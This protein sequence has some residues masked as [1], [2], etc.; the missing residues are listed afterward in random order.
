MTLALYL[1]QNYLSGF[2][3]RKPAFR[4]LEPALRRAVAVDAVAVVE[5]SVHER[6]SRPRPDLGLLDLLRELS[7]GRRLPSTLDA[8]SREVRRRLAWTVARELPERSAR[9]S[10]AADLDALAVAV[11]NC[12][13][14]TSDA[15]MV[16]VVRRSRLDLRH[17]CELFS[18]R[19]PD[20]LRLR[21]RLQELAASAQQ[22]ADRR[23]LDGAQ[24]G[25]EAS[26]R[27]GDVQ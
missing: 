26:G 8:T 10:D 3:K 13:L 19:R 18:G 15:F 17:G 6:E 20:V 22:R 2:A 25:E 16:D 11:C 27:G 14:V 5:S 7:G 4:E 9:G 1:D 21:D 23:G 12:D 24:A